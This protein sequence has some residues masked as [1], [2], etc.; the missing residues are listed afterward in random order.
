MTDSPQCERGA[1]EDV[2]HFPEECQNYSV[3]WKA[4][5]QSLLLSCGIANF[6]TE[7]LL[8]VTDDEDLKDIPPLKWGQV[9]KYITKTRRF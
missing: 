3:P 7:T 8:S 9:D 5:T 6:G 2:Q 4:L 1:I